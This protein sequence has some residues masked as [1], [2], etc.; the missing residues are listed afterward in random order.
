MATNIE[1]AILAT[2]CE[3]GIEE[4]IEKNMRLYPLAYIIEKA[5]SVYN[6]PQ[7]EDSQKAY[8]SALKYHIKRMKYDEKTTLWD[9]SYLK[10]DERPDIDIKNLGNT[11]HFFTL[12]EVNRI[13]NKDEIHHYFVSRSNNDPVVQEREAELRRIH[14][15]Y[16]DFL[17]ESELPED[18]PYM[19]RFPSDAEIE[20]SELRIMIKAIFEMFYTEF[21]SVQYQHDL[22][23]S[24]AFAGNTES[25]LSLE[26]KERLRNPKN[27][28]QKRPEF[29]KNPI[30]ITIK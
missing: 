27:Y 15:A 2:A 26:C 4:I 24:S 16:K 22:M 20:T 23:V 25:M 9:A 17:R 12:V 19:P 18:E 30:T 28:Y 29:V 21:D 13:I 7:D 10:P 11:S 3:Y 1:K 8:E 6:L 14:K 5:I